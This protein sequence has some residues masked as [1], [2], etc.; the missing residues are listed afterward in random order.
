MCCHQFHSRDVSGP[1][2]IAMATNLHVKNT[3]G[4]LEF[5]CSL[6][7]QERLNAKEKKVCVCVFD[8]PHMSA[9]Y[10]S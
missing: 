1:D 6:E 3:G 9:I 8:L 2:S 7:K 10:L 5:R 4:A